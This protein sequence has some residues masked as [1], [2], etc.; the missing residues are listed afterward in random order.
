[1][2]SHMSAAI[3]S[4]GAPRNT[5]AISCEQAQVNR[6]DIGVSRRQCLTAAY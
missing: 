4:S 1:M 5:L 2:L 6:F 3:V